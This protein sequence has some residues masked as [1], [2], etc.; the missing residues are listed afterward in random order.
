MN[1]G[2]VKGLIGLVVGAIFGGVLAYKIQRERW[3]D[4]YYEA[5]EEIKEDY[6][7]GAGDFEE[8]IPESSD[9]SS[10][11]AEDDLI[12]QQYIDGYKAKYSNNGYSDI[13]MSQY[14]KMMDKKQAME[15]DREDRGIK[16]RPYVDHPYY[17][18]EAEYYQMCESVFDYRGYELYFDDE[19]RDVYNVD[20]TLFAE[21]SDAWVHLGKGMFD[22]MN[23]EAPDPLYI[24]NDDLKEVYMLFKSRGSSMNEG[25]HTAG[26]PDNSVWNRYEFDD[27]DPEED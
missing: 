18:S 21:C 2:T 22:V 4:K 5:V 14:Q 10:T 19:T 1:G 15:K 24:Q 11:N 3:V 6:I 27:L 25:R 9:L 12:C 23:D 26:P 13:T 16:L 8:D 20:G 7:R 17:I